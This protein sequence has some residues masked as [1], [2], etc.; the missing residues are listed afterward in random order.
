MSVLVRY[1]LMEVW[2]LFGVATG[3]TLLVLNLL[4]FLKEFLD[5]LILYQAGLFRSLLLLL[6]IQPSFLVLAI[7]IGFL[8]AIL[9]VYGR[10]SSDREVGAMESCGVPFTSVVWPMVGV[11]FLMSLFLIFFMD[12]ILPWGNTS[13]LKL[14]YRIVSEK[15]TVIVRDKVFIHDF[16]GYLLYV[17][18]KDDRKGILEGVTVLFLDSHQQPY[19]LIQA[20]E[21]VLRQDPKNF[22]V[23]LSLKDGILQQ[24][25]AGKHEPA[26][27]FLEMQFKSC[28]LDLSANKLRA[29]PVDFSDARNLSIGKLAERIRDEEK[30]KRD[31]RY[32]RVEF[33][34]KFSIPFSIL[35]FTLIGIP[36][37]LIA[38]TGSVAGPFLAVALVVVYEL[39][40]MFGQAGGPM[41]LVSPFVA[42]WLPN[43]VLIAAGL[44]MIYWRAHRLDVSKVFSR[45]GLDAGT[46]EGDLSGGRES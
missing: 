10:L 33:Q 19:R 13:F 31:V 8:A 26:D 12:R 34:K 18:D 28:S 2:P 43:A 1:C 35:A 21:G 37:G 9:I 7:P 25:G 27:E 22:H 15:S 44:A 45:K 17:R 23:L 16:D 39:F 3:S 46:P 41:G 6:Y 11:S 24:L 38:R 32:D 4:F 42:M 30:K 20:Q 14:Q 40:M 5:Y 36:L 29:G